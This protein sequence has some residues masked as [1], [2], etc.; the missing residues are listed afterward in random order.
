MTKLL[1]SQI[2]H[3][4]HVFQIM[5]LIVWYETLRRLEVVVGGYS[6]WHKF[7]TVIKD[8]SRRRSLK[9]PD[10]G[11]PTVYSVWLYRLTRL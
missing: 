5:S 10:L 7:V 9:S 11:V 6:R 1:K 4:N 2:T 3:K 8:L